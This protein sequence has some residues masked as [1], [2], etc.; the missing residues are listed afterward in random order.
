[1]FTIIT[2]A[3]AVVAINDHMPDGGDA[4]HFKGPPKHKSIGFIIFSGPYTGGVALFH[5][6]LPSAAPSVKASNEDEEH[7]QDKEEENHAAEE[8][9]TNH[10]L[11]EIKHRIF[12]MVLLSLA[13]YNVNSGLQ[14]FGTLFVEKLITAVSW[15]VTGGL[16]SIIFILYVISIVLHFVYST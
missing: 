10:L 15:G 11:W 6:H 12:G 1:M 9:A 8:K 16:S 2:L 3:I 13:W 7:G 14:L 4:E 5:P